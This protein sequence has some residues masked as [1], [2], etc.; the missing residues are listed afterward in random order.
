MIGHY[1]TGAPRMLANLGGKD[2][3]LF[4]VFPGITRSLPL[5]KEPLLIIK[6]KKEK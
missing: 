2:I 6:I 5:K 1:T 4:N 3:P